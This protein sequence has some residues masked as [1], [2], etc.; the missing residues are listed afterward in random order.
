MPNN[1]KS[2]RRRLPRPCFRAWTTLQGL[3]L[4]APPAGRDPGVRKYFRPTSV[5]PSV[6]QSVRQQRLLAFVHASPIFIRPRVA[7]SVTFN[8]WRSS[9]RRQ[10]LLAFVHAS[11]ILSFVQEKRSLTLNCQSSSIRQHRLLAFVHAS[12]ILSFVQEKRSLG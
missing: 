7:P 9:I 5:R 11:P 8:Y 10:R 12:P 3:L 1:L 4:R 6:R 2:R